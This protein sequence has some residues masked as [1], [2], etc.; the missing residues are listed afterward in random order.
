MGLIYEYL[1]YDGV[2]SDDFRVR[3]SGSGT[4]DRPQRDVEAKQIPG[5]NGDLHIDN[6]RY[7]NVKITYPAYITE[8]FE[9]NYAAFAAF[10]FSKRGYKKLEDSYHPEH[11]RRA[12]CPESLNPKM[13]TRNLAGSFDITFDCDPRRFLKTGDEAVEISSGGSINNPTL[14]TAQPLIRVYG[15]GTLTIGGVTVTISA[16]NV[17]TDIDCEI[18]D[19]Y[20]GSTNCNSNLTLNNSKFPEL[21]PGLNTVTYTGFSKVEITPRWW[22]I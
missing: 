10:L 7:N 4:Y 16:A 2:S 5:R 13:S 20:K 6:G 1:T 15:T 12:A 18:M 17:Y 21:A 19:A 11:Y 22:T 14:Y 9:Q 8:D 3:I